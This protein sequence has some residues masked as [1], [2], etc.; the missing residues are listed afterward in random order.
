LFS[1]TCFFFPPI[2][3]NTWVG[4]YHA[5]RP[6]CDAAIALGMTPWQSL[7]QVRIPLAAPLILAGSI[8]FH[9]MFFIWGGCTV[10]YFAT[11]AF[12]MPET[13]GKTLEEIEDHFA[14]KSKAHAK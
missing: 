7:W 5:D 10:L 9:L 1:A 12:L 13:K 6:L 3:T 14:G 8:G 11:A 4:I 2:L